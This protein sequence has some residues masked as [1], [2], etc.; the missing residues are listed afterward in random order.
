MQGY[1]G[2]VTYRQGLSIARGTTIDEYLSESDNDALYA[3]WKEREDWPE[4]YK[5][6]GGVW[7]VTC[8]MIQEVPESDFINA[9]SR[10]YGKRKGKEIA[11]RVLDVVA[12]NAGR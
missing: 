10:K 2:V 9:F 6:S 3:V 5:F 7:A 1:G 12:V 8:E 11:Q 4:P